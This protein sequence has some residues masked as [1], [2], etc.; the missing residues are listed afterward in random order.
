MNN[1]YIEKGFKNRAEYLN[2]LAQKYNVSTNFVKEISE[3][4]GPE[5]DFKGLLSALSIFDNDENDFDESEKNF[6]ENIFSTIKFEQTEIE[7]CLN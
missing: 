1:K 3:I 7:F 5:E 2:S 4:F 6:E